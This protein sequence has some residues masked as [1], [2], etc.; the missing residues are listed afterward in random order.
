MRLGPTVA[1]VAGVALV[2]A[3]VV[4]LG[5]E[6]VIR[7]LLAVGW[8]GFGVICL[9]HVALIV[10]MGVGWWVLV[11]QN[12]KALTISLFCVP[13]TNT[14]L[15]RSWNLR[16]SQSF[17]SDWFQAFIDKVVANSFLPNLSVIEMVLRRR[18]LIGGLS[19]KCKNKKAQ[20]A[21]Q[22]LFDWDT[23]ECF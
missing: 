7:S 3:L 14:L 22:I 5:A 16:S 1:A 9:I 23:A 15:L 2:G 19:E 11:L 6:A 8:A 13:L 4:Y 10:V 18:H 20:N 17:W 12:L 21:H